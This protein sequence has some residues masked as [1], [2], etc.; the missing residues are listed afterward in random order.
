MGRAILLAAAATIGFALPACLPAPAAISVA[1]GGYVA[2]A[3][4]AGGGAVMISSSASIPVL[5]V[6]LQATL[7]L[8]LAKSGG[9][10]V[11]GEVRGLT[12][13]GFGGAYV[14]AGAGIGNLSANRTPG[15]VLTVFAGKPIAPNTAIEIR[16]LQ[17]T[18]NG[19]TTA[20]FLGL[21]FTL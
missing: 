17:S 11:L 16:L 20:G 10:A 9:Y 1:G 14:G 18:R 8:P 4:S 7:F 6:Q 3:P 19:G 5:P 2:K 13:G 21:R 15:P 12:G